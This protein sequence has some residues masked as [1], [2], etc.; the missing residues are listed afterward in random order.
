MTLDSVAW[1]VKVIFGMVSDAYSPCGLGFRLP[2]IVGGQVLT[3]AAFIGVAWVPPAA[4]GGWWW[5]IACAVLRGIGMATVSVAIE[6][7]IVD[8]HV[9]ERMGR[10]QLAMAIGRFIGLLIS[11]L[12]GSAVAEGLGLSALILFSAGF[13]APVFALPMVLLG[14]I[15]EEKGPA[16]KTLHGAPVA[17]GVG[18]A[19]ATS[20]WGG[21]GSS[22][23]FALPGSPP[24][25]DDSA[26]A[27]AA[28]RPALVRSE[29]S[30]RFNLRAFRILCVPS[31]IALLVFAVSNNVGN[32]I[33]TFANVPLLTERGISLSQVGYLNTIGGVAQLP[34]AAITGW[35]M[36]SRDLKGAI[37]ATTLANSATIAAMLIIPLGGGAG[38]FTYLVFVNVIGGLAQGAL[39]VVLV[40][41]TMRGAPLAAAASYVSIVLGV[42][43]AS[44]IIGNLVAGAISN[45]LSMCFIVGAAICI[46]GLLGLPFFGDTARP[47]PTS[48]PPPSSIGD[49]DVEPGLDVVVNPL[50][51]TRV[52]GGGSRPKA[53]GSAVVVAEM[54][55]VLFAPPPQPWSGGR[56]ALISAADEAP[57]PF[58]A[59]ASPQPESAIAQKPH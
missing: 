24:V 15:V 59:L 36:D 12:G 32:T 27:A 33:G 19:S 34:G 46:C 51:S 43:N 53:D 23:S 7:L 16:P 3:T 22:A 39:Y 49:A 29:S 48:K 13:V 54:P 37:A 11:N 8:A 28:P 31:T 41:I 35:L 45:N 14:V 38:A 52:M 20:S 1:T 42:S 17:F 25:A 2:Y 47:P 57:L 4:G 30:H 55:S 26:A 5:Y 9:P 56:S 21:T 50:G 6:G 58:A 10:I 18:A 40:G 44:G